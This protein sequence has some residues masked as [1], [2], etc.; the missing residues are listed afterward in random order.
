MSG[1]VVSSEIWNDCF[2]ENIGEGLFDDEII[3]LDEKKEEDFQSKY[4]LISQN[5]FF[6]RSLQRDF[7]LHGK[8]LRI[9]YKYRFTPL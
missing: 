9:S 4:F 6:A 1:D 5:F 7:V 3:P 8:L 2:M